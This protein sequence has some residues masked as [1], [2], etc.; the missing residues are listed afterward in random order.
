MSPPTADGSPKAERDAERIASEVLG[1]ESSNDPFVAAVRATRMPMIIT[2]PRQ[3]DNPVVFANDSFCRLTGYTR[4]EILG[5]N[6]R[7]LQGPETDPETIRR[8]HDAVASVQPIE[9]DI[10]NHRKD[11]QPFWNRLLLA[12]VFDA[13]GKLAYFFASQVDVTLERERLDDLQS[14]NAALSA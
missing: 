3:S 7:F 12:P 1:L 2:D 13:D 14:D 8:I 5:R 6:C 11:G 10:R 9:I 4:A